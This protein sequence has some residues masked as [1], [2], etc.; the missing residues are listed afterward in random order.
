MQTSCGPCGSS[1]HQSPPKWST[2]VYKQELYLLDHISGLQ[3]NM[4]ENRAAHPYSKPPRSPSPRRSRCRFNR[5]SHLNCRC[6]RPLHHLSGF[7]NTAALGPLNCYV[8]TSQQ[9]TR[10]SFNPL[11][12]AFEPGARQLNPAPHFF[13]LHA[14]DSLTGASF[15]ALRSPLTLALP[16]CSKQPNST[17]SAPIRNHI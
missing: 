11:A 9:C 12:P 4:N 14:S 2:V 7:K 5:L 10:S 3:I 8:E 17:V 6:C 16:R 13:D 1:T 15:P